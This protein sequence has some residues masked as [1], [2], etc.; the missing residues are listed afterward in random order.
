MRIQLSEH[1][2]YKKLLRFVLP[3]IIMMIFTSI[4]GIVDGIFVSNYVGKTPF[5]AVNF[6]MP[7]LMILGGVGFMIGTGGSALV[8]QTMGEGDKKR[9][10][11]YFSMLIYAT[12]ILGVILAA[13]GIAFIRPITVLLGA[14]DEMVEYCVSYARIILFTIPAFM[15]QNVFQ[16][17]FVTAEKPKLGLAVT[18]AAGVTN[19]VLDYLFIAVLNLGVEGAAA[20]TAISQVVGA[21]LPLFYF[22]APNSSLLRLSR[23]KFD[24]KALLKTCTNGSS[25]LV[26]NISLSLVNM[27]YNIQLL[28]LIGED[29]VSAY[30]VIMYVNLVFLSIFIGHSIGCAPIVGYH[31][32]AGNR[33]ELKG[34]FR[35]SLVIIS[36]AGISMIVISELL[37]VPLA[38][39]F[40]G[41]DAELLALTCHGF[42]LYAIS[43]A[44][45]GFNIFGSAF[46]T[47]L[48][49][50]IISAAISFLR[51]LLFQ[52]S[53]VLLLPLVLDAD[54][55][56][57]AIVAAEAAAL[58]V[59]AIFTI[60]E[61]KRYGYL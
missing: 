43:F 4:Y 10:N 44:I 14:K 3:S 41:Y 60:K 20:A 40:V 18:I 27:L 23:A 1:F 47:A 32:G 33:E 48:G 17:F 57:L 35:K 16:S 21:I 12:L 30:G 59:T 6:I 25:E 42:R 7:V 13:L 49:N 55:I 2:T 26:T 36:I 50:G 11:S 28:R 52:I 53:A 45:C 29:G 54:G 46:F 61:R 5:A 37:A 56:W 22:F 38:T 8:S 15:L 31:Y 51:T 34:L 19:M 24:G 9:A 39:V 58:V